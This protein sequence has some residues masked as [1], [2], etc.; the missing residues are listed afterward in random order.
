MSMNF[1]Q[2][3]AMQ[4]AQFRAPA[5]PSAAAGMAREAASPM[6]GAAQG[7]QAAA[8]DDDA[9]RETFTSVMGEMLFHEMVK[10][11]RRSLD[12]PAYF[13]GGHAED[14]FTGRLDQVLS[15]KLGETYGEEYFGPMYDAW[16][17]R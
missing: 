10:S 5:L 8:D 6:P 16:A 9:A 14:M 4:T 13:H 2:P 15:Q 3:T 11:M 12:K 17:N 7:P 1:I